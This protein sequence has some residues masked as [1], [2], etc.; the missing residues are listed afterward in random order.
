MERGRLVWELL[1]RLVVEHAGEVWWTGGGGGLRKKLDLVQERIG[2]RLLGCSATVAGVAVRGELGWWSLGERREG[3]KVGQF[4]ES[5]LVAK[6]V[7]CAKEVGGGNLRGKYGIGDESVSEKVSA[8]LAVTVG[9]RTNSGQ[10]CYVSGQ[11]C[12]LSGQK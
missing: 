3:K 4:D 9:H 8:V 6:V 11:I 5:R 1:G 10:S 7:S 2:R 12:Y